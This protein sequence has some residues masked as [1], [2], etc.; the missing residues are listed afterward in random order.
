M[1]DGDFL[2]EMVNQQGATIIHEMCHF[3]KGVLILDTRDL[4]DG[5]FYAK[6]ITDNSVLATKVIKN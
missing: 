3:E 6:V 5:M 1:F 2:V 4:S